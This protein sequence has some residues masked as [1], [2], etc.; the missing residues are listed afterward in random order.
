MIATATGGTFESYNPT[1][2]NPTLAAVVDTVR[3]NPMRAVASGGTA[4]TSRSWDHPN[5]PLTAG[6]IVSAVLCLYL[7]V[8]RR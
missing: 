7:A 5:V 2:A 1:G 8:L 6:L 3:A 4:I